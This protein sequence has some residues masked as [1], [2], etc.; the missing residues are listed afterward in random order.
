QK[1]NKKIRSRKNRT[2][3]LSKKAQEL[4]M[5]NFAASAPDKVIDGN[6]QVD[7]RVKMNDNYM[8]TGWYKAK[9]K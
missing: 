9:K 5:K 3:V 6:I 4:A 7:E 8:R 1:G 2:G